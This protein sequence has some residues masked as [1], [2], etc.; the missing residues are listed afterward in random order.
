MEKKNITKSENLKNGG[1]L[2]KLFYA[3][4]IVNQAYHIKLERLKLEILLNEEIKLYPTNTDLIRKK[5]EFLKN[6][7]KA[8]EK[9]L[10]IAKRIKDYF[11]ANP[12]L[13]ESNRTSLKQAAKPYWD[14]FD[15]Q[16]QCEELYDEN[17][18]E[19][20][21]LPADDESELF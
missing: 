14:S 20:T 21:S 17:G 9:D 12:E 2:A 18:I 19:H 13:P 5:E 1:V 10:M 15:C 7:D 6:F 11:E 8:H 3:M 16:T 4:N